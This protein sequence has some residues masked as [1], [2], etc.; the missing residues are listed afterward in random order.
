[1]Q[2]VAVFCSVLVCCSVLQCVA[3]CC[4]GSGG[5]DFAA[6]SGLSSV[7]GLPASHPRAHTSHS[8]PCNMYVY[9]NM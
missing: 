2:C 1:M 4:R 5:F 6:N 8:R 9:V 7:K 3:V